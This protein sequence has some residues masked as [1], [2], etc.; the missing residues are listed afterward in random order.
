[1]ELLDWVMVVFLAIV[2]VGGSVWFLYCAYT[3]DKDKK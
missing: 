2:F 1:M 3:S